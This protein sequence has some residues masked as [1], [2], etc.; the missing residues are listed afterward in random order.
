MLTHL[1]T[2]KK[3]NPVSLLWAVYVRKDVIQRA[4]PMSY[5]Y[6]LSVS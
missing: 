4:F 2:L 3:A 6:T 1:K 5:V